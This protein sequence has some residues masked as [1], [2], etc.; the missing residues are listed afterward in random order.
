VKRR[1]KVAFDRACDGHVPSVFRQSPEDSEKCPPLPSL[2]YEV[3][4]VIANARP[5]HASSG[6]PA[7]RKGR[8]WELPGAKVKD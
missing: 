2:N 4:Y 5:D 7:W 3:R 8:E 6:R 1:T